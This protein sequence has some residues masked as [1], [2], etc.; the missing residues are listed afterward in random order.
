MTRAVTLAEIAD[1]NTF[2]VDGTNNRVGINSSIPTT[3][4]DVGGAIKATSFT[5]NATGLNGTPDIAVRNITGVAATFTGLLT[6]EDVTNID[7]VGIVTARTGVRIADGGLIV[8]AGVSTFAADISIADKII[9]T[10]D[11]NTAI[12][13]PANDTVTVETA[14]TE[15]LRVDSN[16]DVGIN[17]TSPETHLHV[18]QD[19]AHS[20]TYYTN[21]DAAILLQNNNTGASAKTVLKLEAPPSS[22]DCAIVYGGGTTNLIFSDR[23]NE[24]LRI[25]SAGRLGIN[26]ST[27][28]TTFHSTGTTN[29]QQATFGIDDSGLKIS[30]FQKTDNDA[31]VILDAQKSSNGT[32][33][34]ATAGTERLRIDSSGNGNFGAVK[35]VALPS[36]TGIQV[37]NSSTPRIKLVNDT[38]GNASGDGLQIYVTGSSAV[39]DQKE[40]AEMRFYTNATEKARIDSSGNFM[41]GATSASGKFHVED[42]GEVLAYII[43]NTSSAG[44]RLVLQ[45]KNT[46]ANSKTG[47]LGADAGGQTTAQVL[48]YSADNDTNE[49]YLTLETRPASGVPTEAMRIDSSQRVLIGATSYG[50]GGTSPDLYISSTSG[51]QLKIHNTNSS[52]SSLQLTNAATGQGDDNGLQIAALSDGTAYFNQVESSPMRFDVNGSERMRIDSS[53]AI[54]FGTASVIQTEKYTFFRPESE[55]STLAYFHSGASADVSGVLFRH[56]RALSGYNGKQIGFLRSDGNEVGSIISGASSTSFNTSSDYRLKEN[57][58]S[59]SDGITR[60][61][62]LKPYRFNFTNDTTKPVVDGFFAHEVTAVPEAITGTKDQV[63]ADNNPVYQSIDQSKI[64]PLLTAALQEAIAKIETLSARLD[65]GGL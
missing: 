20:S 5:G 2:V 11:P 44:S 57:A 64:V 51:R 29:G 54:R 16:G 45:N 63:D 25:T 37:Y 19:N 30:T 23:Q 53:G 59:I 42:S 4:L 38:T 49:G 24:R 34:F 39:F 9:H 13:F 41:I 55:Q 31:G 43:G 22:S 33:T 62:T 32:L 10:G 12:R 47:V 52:T 48:F 21:A 58:V 56:G 6:Y 60:L 28:Q 3:T 40:N 15:R 50:G 18:E 35:A 27:P 7:S 8:T 65:A 26:Q 14:G 17:E 1:T 61:K 36:G 46:T